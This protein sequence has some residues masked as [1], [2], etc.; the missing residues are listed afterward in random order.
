MASLWIAVQGRLSPGLRGLV[1][2]FGITHD[3]FPNH[4][5]SFTADGDAQNTRFGSSLSLSLKPTLTSLRFLR[6]ENSPLSFLRLGYTAPH[7]ADCFNLETTSPNLASFLH[8]LEGPVEP[9]LNA[10][11]PPLD[12]FLKVRTIFRPLH[13][14]SSL[15]M[16]SASRRCGGSSSPSVAQ[17]WLCACN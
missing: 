4:C 10:A 17:T 9:P 5:L 14:L 1:G 13:S 3:L 11:S 16:M 8:R 6:K 2:R 7:I 15:W 12:E